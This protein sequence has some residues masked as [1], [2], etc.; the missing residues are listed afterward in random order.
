MKKA[1]EK[2][3]HEM[4]YEDFLQLIIEK[5]KAPEDVIQCELFDLLGYEH[6]EFIEYLITNRKPVLTWYNNK[7]LHKAIVSSKYFKKK[8]NLNKWSIVCF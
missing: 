4:S 7:K 6:L 5:L 3:R 1:Y 8:L 2:Y